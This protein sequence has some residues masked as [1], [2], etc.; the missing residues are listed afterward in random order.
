MTVQSTLVGRAFAKVN[1]GLEVLAKRDDGY[2]EIRTILQTVDLHDELT[3]ERQSD[4]I[5]LTT[6]DPA[7]T[8]GPEN[9]VHRAATLLAESAPTRRLGASIHLDKRIPAGMGLGGGSADAAVTLMALDR[10]WD[11]HTP[12]RDL[13]L[14]AASIGMDVP[15][16]LYGGTALAVGRGDEVYP[17]ALEADWPIV[18]ILPDF[19]I[20][21]ATAY[22]SLILTKRRSELT[23]QHFAWR[24]P[25][26]RDGLGE[27]VNHLEGATGSHTSDIQEYKRV[28][29]DRGAVAAMMSGSGSA[30]FGV[31]EDGHSA[32]SIASSLTREGLRAV[33]TSTVTRATYRDKTLSGGTS[34]TG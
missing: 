27:L 12:A 21:T 6:S 10:L 29:L 2:H 25:S 16:F 1:L 15:F 30:V 19:S 11:L 8:S 3:F 4:G 33:A 31:F 34:W 7:I 32:Q 23:L 13:H 20:A 22:A 18:L 5:A 14:M 17:L 24:S 26:V 9:L 28:L